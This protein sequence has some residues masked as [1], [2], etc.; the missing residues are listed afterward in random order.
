[1]FSLSC[2]NFAN[3]LFTFNHLSF[4]T[5]VL[6]Y[7]IDT[8]YRLLTSY[9]CL[10]HLHNYYI[11][12]SNRVVY[13]S[14]MT[15]SDQ[16]STDD[17]KP[18]RIPIEEL[19]KLDKHDLIDQ[20]SS[21]FDYISSQQPED[22]QA[23]RD[24]EEKYRQ[25]VTDITR[26]E[27]MLLKTLTE[28]EREISDL[29]AQIEELKQ[30]QLPSTNQLRTML[31]EPTVNV[32]I[33]RLKK[34]LTSTKLRLE[35]SQSELNAWKFTQDSQTGKQLMARCRTLLKENEELG[36]QISQGRIAKLEGEIALQKKLVEEMKV[37]QN[38]TELFVVELD[39][40]TEGLQTTIYLLQQ[41]LKEAKEH[42]ASLEQTNSGTA[43]GSQ[44]TNSVQPMVE[45]MECHTDQSDGTV[46]N[47]THSTSVKDSQPNE[48][49]S[50]STNEKSIPNGD[51]S[52]QLGTKSE[53]VDPENDTTG[54]VDDALTTGINKNGFPE[55][56]VA[57]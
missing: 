29:A 26:R 49:K 55:M 47:H 6:V 18:V 37:A 15:E 20:I 22:I 44:S 38:E 4:A 39:D 2:S 5:C 14:S 16:A 30:Y 21:L 27:S 56:M 54:K 13:I 1:M 34:E 36:K 43:K 8:E 35:E 23:L 28:K 46:S 31:V 50:C 10:L 48:L 45:P 53:S 12:T 41:Q 24:A 11:C 25:Q 32:V 51:V 40:D 19:E 57:I 42:I 9:S 17:I 33:N 52:L 7:F 3:F